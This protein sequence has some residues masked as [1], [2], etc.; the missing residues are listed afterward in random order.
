MRGL[1]P[2]PADVLRLELDIE[3]NGYLFTTGMWFLV[4]DLPAATL[5]W[6]QAFTADAIAYLVGA[7]N[8][9]T[10]SGAFLSTCRVAAGGVGGFRYASYA[11]TNVGAYSGGQADI[12]ASGVFIRSNSGT[13]G[14]GSRLRFPACPDAFL[15]D[16]VQL[17]AAGLS[18]L[19]D[20][21][22]AITSFSAAELGPSGAPVVLGTL[23]RAQAGAPLPSA[24]FD[25]ALAVVPSLRIEYLDRRFPQRRYV[26]PF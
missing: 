7:V 2:V 9:V 25:P 17:S 20:M 4:P 18:R 24:I 1:P 22:T 26:S 13:R 16:N 6:Y 15:T 21:C 12:V 19:L 10:H 3:V 11:G 14:S 5:P 23:R 8:G